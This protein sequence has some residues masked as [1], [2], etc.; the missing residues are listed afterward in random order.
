VRFAP[1]LL[2]ALTVLAGCGGESDEPSSARTQATP[3][4]T[5]EPRATPEPTSQEI[6]EV[7]NRYLAA[8][9]RQDWSGLCAT[10]VPSQQRQF[11]RLA[12]SCERAFRTLRSE[13]R[14]LV[15]NSRAGEIRV[16]GKRATIE[17]TELG[18]R[19]P[20]MR[21]Y[22]IEEDGAWGVARRKRG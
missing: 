19:E 17:V 9:A 6:R 20:Y 2:V 22:A 21:L 12:G 7:V 16:R 11:D 4:A 15:R 1:W 14:E 18:W 8:Y 13:K 5:P 3:T 10:L